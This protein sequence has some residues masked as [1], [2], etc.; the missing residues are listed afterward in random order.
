[1]CDVEREI[2]KILNVLINHNNVNVQR[3]LQKRQKLSSILQK[4]AKGAIVSARFISVRDMD[5][6]TAYFV[7]LEK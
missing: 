5:A 1:M 2:S 3:D 6:P 7:N 4:K